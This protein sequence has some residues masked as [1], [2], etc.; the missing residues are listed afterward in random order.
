MKS[1]LTGIRAAVAQI[2]TKCGNR[3]ALFGAVPPSINRR[4]GVTPLLF[5][6]AG[7]VER[8]GHSQPRCNEQP[9]DD[10]T[11]DVFVRRGVIF[12]RESLLGAIITWRRKMNSGHCK[13]CAPS[14][15]SLLRTFGLQVH[16]A[17]QSHVRGISA[18]TRHPVCPSL[19]VI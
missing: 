6:S 11:L 13:I 1:A 5:S 2:I 4:K 14:S 10:H 9:I 17:L 15:S 7:W 3:I 19:L 12:Y 18:D 8:S 16:Q